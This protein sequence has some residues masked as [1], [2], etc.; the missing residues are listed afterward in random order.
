MENEVLRPIKNSQLSI[1]NSQLTPGR[2]RSGIPPG[3][4]VCFHRRQRRVARVE[5]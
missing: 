5:I 2:D 3:L 4:V 1:F